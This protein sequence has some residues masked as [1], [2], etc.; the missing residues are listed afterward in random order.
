MSEW[1]NVDYAKPSDK[2]YVWCFG[3]YDGY[4]EMEG[5]EGYYDATRGKWWALNNGD[6]VDGGYGNDYESK[7]THWMPLPAPPEK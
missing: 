3:F 4:D 5:F 1:I 6:Y 2:E 7:V